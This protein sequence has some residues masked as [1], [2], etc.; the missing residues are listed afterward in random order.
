MSTNKY[1]VHRTYSDEVRPG[2]YGDPSQTTL[3]LE[4]AAALEMFRA[5]A[6]RN[7]DGNAIQD[8]YGRILESELDELSDALAVGIL[9]SGFPPGERVAIY[10]QNIAQLVISQ[11]GTWRP[12]ASPSLSTRCTA[13]ES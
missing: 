13:P 2:M 5:T 6:H 10:A 4:H 3:D 7:P 12:T 11:L 8:Y 1:A 9:E